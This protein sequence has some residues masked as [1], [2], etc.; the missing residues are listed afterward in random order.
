MF[1]LNACL[2][3]GMLPRIDA[4]RPLNG[5]VI[6]TACFRDGPFIFPAAASFTRQQR[7]APAAWTIPIMVCFLQLNLQSSLDGAARSEAAQCHPAARVG[8]Q[9]SSLLSKVQSLVSLSLPSRSK[10]Q[11]LPLPATSKSAGMKAVL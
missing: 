8:S 2:Y 7:L 4:G 6:S 9:C 1:T 10:C 5:D 3:V 11:P